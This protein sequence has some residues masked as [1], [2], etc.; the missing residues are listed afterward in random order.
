MTALVI[1][2]GFVSPS[3]EAQVRQAPSATSAH[4]DIH[5]EFRA[6][7][8]RYEELIQENDRL[9]DLTQK[10]YAD[11]QKAHQER[12]RAKAQDQAAKRKIDAAIDRLN[13]ANRDAGIRISRIGL[14]MRKLDLAMARLTRYD[15]H[16]I[17]GGGFD[18]DDHDLRRPKVTRIDVVRTYRDA[19]GKNVI[20]YKIT[21]SDGAKRNFEQIVGR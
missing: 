7:E 17:E 5:K 9:L 18:H 6:L 12:N 10:R 21:Y 1:A 15:N 8:Q 19:S 11:L 20:A 16:L 14:E 3:L 13:A 2:V 4:R